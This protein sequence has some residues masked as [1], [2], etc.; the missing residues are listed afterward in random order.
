MQLVRILDA[1]NYDPPC[2]EFTL[3]RGDLVKVRS[4]RRVE[5]FILWGPDG[6]KDPYLCCRDD[7]VPSRRCVMS[8]GPSGVERVRHDGHWRRILR[9]EWHGMVPHVVLGSVS[10]PKVRLPL[11][12]LPDSP[13]PL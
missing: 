10:G 8:I 3:E 13:S 7:G 1:L 5:G 2:A 6:R 12:D 9:H 11:P 4:V